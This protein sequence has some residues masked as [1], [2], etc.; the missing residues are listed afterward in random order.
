[1]ALYYSERILLVCDLTN[2]Y[3]IMF[4]N[5]FDKLIMKT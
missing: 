2:A 1:M 3:I 5:V 4:I